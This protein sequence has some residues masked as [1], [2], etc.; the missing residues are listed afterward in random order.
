MSSWRA[1]LHSPRIDNVVGIDLASRDVL[2]AVV[3]DI[4]KQLWMLRARLPAAG[5]VVMSFVLR[6]FNGRRS[7]DGDS[8]ASPTR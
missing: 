4:K 3:R 8:V 1:R 5:Q 2:I 6:G 7:D